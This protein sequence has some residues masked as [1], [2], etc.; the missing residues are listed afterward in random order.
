MALEFTLVAKKRCLVGDPKRDNAELLCEPGEL[1][2]FCQNWELLEVNG[3]VD[4]VYEVDER[5]AARPAI[6]AKLNNMT[7]DELR[8]L[9]VELGVPTHH[10][11]GSGTSG[12][13]LK[14][15]LITA[16]EAVRAN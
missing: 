7:K 4:R 10:V 2:P 11:Q 13:V 12:Y 14:S 15:D 3:Y 9:L 5:R 1:V 6:P 16:V 8:D